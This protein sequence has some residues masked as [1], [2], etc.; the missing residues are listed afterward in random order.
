MIPDCHGYSNDVLIFPRISCIPIRINIAARLVFHQLLDEMK[1]VMRTELL[2][3]INSRFEEI[4]SD[5]IVL[6]YT[7]EM[8]SDAW[9]KKDEEMA[10][11]RERVVLL[12]KV[13]H[14]RFQSKYLEFSA[15]FLKIVSKMEH[16]TNQLWTQLKSNPFIQTKTQWRWKSKVMHTCLLT[17]RFHHTCWRLDGCQ[18]LYSSCLQTW[19]WL[20]SLIAADGYCQRMIVSSSLV[21]FEVIR[22]VH[23]VVLIDDELD[24]AFCLW[25]Y[26]I[27]WRVANSIC[28][29]WWFYLWSSS[30]WECSI[31]R[32]EQIREDN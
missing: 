7:A 19:A 14:S 12:I 32:T 15:L 11:I 5:E 10:K 27:S 21:V 1:G 22:T 25:D 13:Q 24:A 26:R 4:R 16:G 20:E 29:K 18:L 9:R 17:S 8:W 23:P 31:K 3:L 2:G 6:S 28:G 30:Q